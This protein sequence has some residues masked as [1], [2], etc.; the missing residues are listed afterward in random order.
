MWRHETKKLTQPLILWKQIKVQV[1]MPRESLNTST[2]MHFTEIVQDRYLQHFLCSFA[3]SLIVI[4]LFKHFVW[5]L[6][7]FWDH[8]I[9]MEL[10]PWQCRVIRCLSNKKVC[11]TF[12]VRCTTSI[13]MPKD[14]ST[15]VS[16][17]WSKAN[18]SA[19]CSKEWTAGQTLAMFIPVDWSH[20]KRVTP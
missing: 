11:I 10:M 16:D 4:S 13:W 7:Q 1:V 6:W 19:S 3:C 12:T 9:L 17:Y 14:N 18:P 8:L 2:D 20:W 5:S 15:I